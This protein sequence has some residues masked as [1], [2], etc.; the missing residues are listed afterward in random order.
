MGDPQVFQDP[1]QVPEIVMDD[2]HLAPGVFQPLGS[3]RNGILILIDADEQPFRVQKFHHPM[4]MARPAQ[5]A[6]HIDPLGIRDHPLDTF[7]Q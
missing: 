6:V 2:L 5:G 3:C 4:G 1:I 7:F